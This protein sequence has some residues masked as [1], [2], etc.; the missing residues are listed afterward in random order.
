[1]RNLYEAAHTYA[2]AQRQSL[3]RGLSDDSLPS[4]VQ[5]QQVE[6]CAAQK[7]SGSDPS[8]P[9]PAE[10]GCALTDGRQQLPAGACVA[11]A[12]PRRESNGP[13]VVPDTQGSSG[14]ERS[15]AIARPA[16]DQL[17]PHQAVPLPYSRSSNSG[18]QE[19]AAAG[20]SRQKE[21][22]EQLDDNARSMPAAEKEPLVRAAA[23]FAQLGSP[24]RMQRLPGDTAPAKKGASGQ[25]KRL[26]EGGQ[27]AGCKRRALS[28]NQAEALLCRKAAHG[29]TQP[30]AAW[31][32]NSDDTDDFM[33]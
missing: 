21:V 2:A 33:L 5:H 25:I 6:D 20:S 4:A 13:S 7:P 8:T 29:S 23:D 11:A 10:N 32:Q 15:A 19:A 26:S 24:T 14:S 1:M 27:G 9:S 22:E 28:K 31:T 17:L 12:L 30:S 3:S 18:Q 16:T